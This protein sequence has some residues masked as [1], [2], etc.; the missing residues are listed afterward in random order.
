MDSLNGSANM[1]LE[2]IGVFNKTFALV[3]NDKLVE[4]FH[5]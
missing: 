4:A 5:Y 3:A 2:V 1:Q